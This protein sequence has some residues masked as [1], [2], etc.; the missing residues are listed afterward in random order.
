MQD[1]LRGRKSL[2]RVQRLLGKTHRHNVV[3]VAALRTP[4]DVLERRWLP[5]LGMPMDILV[6]QPSYVHRVPG[7]RGSRLPTASFNLHGK[8]FFES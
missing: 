1:R 3:R 8:R 2:W 7:Y 5:P 6:A 4:G